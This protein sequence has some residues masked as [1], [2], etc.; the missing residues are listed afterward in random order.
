MT[1]KA[2]LAVIIISFFSLL[3]AG[4]AQATQI[5]FNVTNSDGITQSG[6]KV[7]HYSNTLN[8][9]TSN[10]YYTDVNGQLVVDGK[11]IVGDK[12]LFSRDMSAMSTTTPE[13]SLSD[14]IGDDYGL[15]YTFSNQDL[16]VKE[17]ILPALSNNPLK[18]SSNITPQVRLLVGLINKER[19][20][21]GLNQIP[22]SLV[23]N[24]SAQNFASL[25]NNTGSPENVH[26]YNSTF[27]VR[28]IDLG[29]P[30][31]DDP[32]LTR[33]YQGGVTEVI[34]LW[35]KA[36]PQQII[37]GWMNSPGHRRAL[38]YQTADTIGIGYTD[39]KVVAVLADIDQS[40][41]VAVNKAQ[42]SNDYG[43]PDLKIINNESKP[44]NNGNSAQVRRKYN[45]RLTVR[46]KQAGKKRVKLVIRRAAKARG[47]IIVR[48][49]SKLIRV[50]KGK[51]VVVVVRKK[52]KRMRIKVR[53][54]SSN[55]SFKSKSLVRVKRF[56]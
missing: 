22:I 56:R 9:Q 50:S 25:L 24:N 37:N 15:Q 2:V 3:T 7:L 35:A 53:F 23:L 46:I 17:I 55:K 12:F 43:D 51:R 54:I 8:G 18:N 52:S 21:Q 33:N 29:F 39:N 5:T 28:A 13:N 44:G 4:S 16:P 42:L 34:H 48:V 36:G 30:S 1:K 40:N 31:F 27:T 14:P 41:P 10:Y 20:K 32:N 38:L 45:P 26:Y 47:K 19:S 6:V 11:I 49:N